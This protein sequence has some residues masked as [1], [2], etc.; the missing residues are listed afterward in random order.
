[1]MACQHGGTH[2]SRRSRPAAYLP[3]PA[4]ASPPT[5]PL[6]SLSGPTLPAV[7]TGGKRA[8]HPGTHPDP[9]NWLAPQ[10]AAPIGVARERNGAALRG[11]HAGTEGR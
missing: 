2:A 6:R 7:R 9:A 4:P 11:R 10:V 8:G 1:M 5:T 3:E